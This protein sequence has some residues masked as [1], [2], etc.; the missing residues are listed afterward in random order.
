MVGLDLGLKTGY[1]QRNGDTMTGTSTDPGLTAVEILFKELMVDDDW[2]IRRERGFTWWS[3]RLAQHVEAT[4][5]FTVNDGTLASFIRVW[6]DVVSDVSDINAAEEI[7]SFVNV[8]TSMSA[9]ILEPDDRS[10]SECFT[11]VVYADNAHGW[12]KATSVAAVLQNVEA[13]AFS[14]ALAEAVG[15]Q[16]DV[17]EHPINGERPVM[18]DILNVPEQVIKPIGMGRS[19]FAG[20]MIQKLTTMD[21]A[22]WVL[23]NG[24]DDSFTA[25]VHYSSDVTA[26]EVIMLPHIYQEGSGTALIQVLI[27]EPHQ[28]LGSGAVVVL[29]LPVSFDEDK[30]AHVAMEMN[31]LDAAGESNAPMMGAWCQEPGDPNSIA[32]FSFVP[33]FMAWPGVLENLITY[34][35]IR[36][37]WAH[38]VL[39]EERGD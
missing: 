7:L 31:R 12:A 11:F 4:P 34:N 23:A 2:S 25:E 37:E 17:S 14:E 16:P 28:E 3:Y 32:F 19:K 26:E 27:R 35:S 1:G 8:H 22:P 10:I 29:K 18:D 38:Q 21:P 9:L 33:S 15:G 30:V 20:P 36:A 13:H 5:I 6:T 39:G 24:D